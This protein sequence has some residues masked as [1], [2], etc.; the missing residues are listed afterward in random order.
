MTQAN[1]E[2]RKIWTNGKQGCATYV[3]VT[4]HDHCIAG[5]GDAKHITARQ[6]ERVLNR[7]F[8]RHSFVF[9]LYGHDCLR[10]DADR[11]AEDGL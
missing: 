2:T 6:M 9:N 4:V 5:T 8:P 10:A 7:E 1:Y 3:Y 11:W